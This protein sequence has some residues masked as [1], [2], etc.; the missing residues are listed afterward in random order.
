MANDTE[1][2]RV[3]REVNGWTRLSDAD[4]QVWRERLGAIRD[5]RGEIIN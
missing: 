3:V 4:L 5:R 1:P 2:L